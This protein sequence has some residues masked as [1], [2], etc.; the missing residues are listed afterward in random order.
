VGFLQAYTQLFGVDFVRRLT[1]DKWA[2]E[3][4]KGHC[5]DLSQAYWDRLDIGPCPTNDQL[6]IWTVRGIEVGSHVAQCEICGPLYRF[7]QS[8]RRESA[9]DADDR[10][11]ETRHKGGQTS[12][13]SDATPKRTRKKAKQPKDQESN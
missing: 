7:M 5:Q 4:L 2:A 13:Q 9:L 3:H 8:Q 11:S 12:R 1:K 10:A 6:L